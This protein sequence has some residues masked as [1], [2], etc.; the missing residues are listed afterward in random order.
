MCAAETLGE[1]LRQ[2]RAYKKV[3]LEDAAVRTDIPL[4][5]L[6]AL[7]ADEFERVPARAYVRAYLRSYSTFLG[8]PADAV[9]EILDEQWPAQVPAGVMPALSPVRMPRRINLPLVL[10]FLGLVAVAFLATRFYGRLDSLFGGDAPAGT[11]SEPT[12]IAASTVRSLPP[13]G[14]SGQAAGAATPTPIRRAQPTQTSASA[15][16]TAPAPM[17]P[18][19][20]PPASSTPT[21]LPFESPPAASGSPV[22]VPVVVATSISQ[23]TSAPTVLQATVVAGVTIEVRLSA[24]SWLQVEVDGTVQF[25]GLLAPGERRTWTG[26]QQIFLWVGNAGGVEV[27]HNGK[28]EGIL[29]AKDEVQKITWT[30]SGRT[31]PVTSTPPG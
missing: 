29:G 21:V 20:P 8:L 27:V 28:P 13:S 26:K 14:L 23:P 16:P 24:S 9:L 3:S 2:A 6:T 30:A 4:H 19:A 11:A 5:H 25:Q 7:E 1:I 31:P 10:A 15:A 22:A 12:A 18:T 17:M